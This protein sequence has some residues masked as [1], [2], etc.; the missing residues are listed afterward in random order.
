MKTHK[1]NISDEEVQIIQVLDDL[2]L[3]GCTLV[4]QVENNVLVEKEGEYISRTH[5][6]IIK[7][8]NEII[9]PFHNIKSDRFSPGFYC[10]LGFAQ[11]TEKNDFRV[12]LLNG[13]K[14]AIGYTIDKQDSKEVKYEIFRIID[15]TIKGLVEDGLEINQ[16]NLLHGDFYNGNVMFSNGKYSLIDFEYVR[17][18]PPQLEWAFLL[19]WDLIVEK[20]REKR[21]KF[22][23]KVYSDLKILMTNNILSNEDLKLMFELYLP[24]LV[25]L[26]LNSCDKNTF[27]DENIIREGLMRFWKKEYN[28]I[29]GDIYG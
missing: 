24:C 12:Y 27:N 20:N 6:D 16:F 8:Y 7:M 29:K 25:C 21:E 23:F 13:L 15:K 1:K 28:I 2:K 3:L 14:E 19:F 11:S 5:W 10:H 22:F 17:F 9:A 18:G 4:Q 26:S